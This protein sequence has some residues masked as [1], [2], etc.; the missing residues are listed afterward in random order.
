MKSN[1]KRLYLAITL[2]LFAL[3]AICV[4]K[5]GAEAQQGPP[6]L[7]PTAEPVAVL[8]QVTVLEQSQVS[9]SE[10]GILSSLEVRQ[11]LPVEAGQELGRLDDA[12]PRIEQM[13]AQYDLEIA[14]RNSTD[15]LHVRYAKAEWDVAQSEYHQ[16]Q[17]AN[18][19]VDNTI[20]KSEMRRRELAVE[21]A[22]LEHERAQR[23]HAISG[24]M[25]QSREA[26]LR[27][28]TVKLQRRS[29]IAPISGIVV[30]VHKQLGEW[31]TPGDPVLRILR[32][33]RLRVEADLKAD[34]FGPEVAGWP[35]TVTAQWPNGRSEHFQGKIMFASPEIEPVNNDFRVYAEVINRNNLLRPGMNVHMTLYPPTQTARSK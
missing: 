1:P 23:E 4:G 11:G 24:V 17:E 15:D 9:A 6:L 28:A 10:A 12:L 8:G 33:D 26:A 7:P 3:W 19:K 35:V 18:K 34:R 31:V 2:A 16:G 13:Q 29:I 25:M 27:T 32:I 30:N 20:T 21:R 5:P 22:R 14:Q